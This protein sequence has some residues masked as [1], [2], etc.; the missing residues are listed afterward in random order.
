VE[1]IY[2]LVESQSGKS[3]FAP[4]YRLIDR[5]FLILSPIDFTGSNDKYY[6]QKDHSEVN[7]PLKLTLCKVADISIVSNKTI[8]VDAD[9][10]RY[11]LVLRRWNEEMFFNLWHE[12]KI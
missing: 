11:P 8:F 9:K 3:I 4:E 10:I 7:I 6:I 12:W 2:D 5:E 1:D